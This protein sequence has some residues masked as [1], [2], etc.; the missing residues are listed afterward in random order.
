MGSSFHLLIFLW[1]SGPCTNLSENSHFPRSPFLLAGV[2]CDLL[3]AH[4]FKSS[5]SSHQVA[6]LP[7]PGAIWWSFLTTKTQKSSWISR[8]NRA[9][10]RG[11]VSPQEFN[12]VVLMPGGFW[13][14]LRPLSQ[15]HPS[16]QL[17]HVWKWNHS[18]QNCGPFYK[19]LEK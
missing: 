2:A 9:E 17:C 12:P 10:L 3:S 15:A 19:L 11:R 5:I 4:H 7:E 13:S 1:K 16:S 18:W 14:C 6:N 8:A